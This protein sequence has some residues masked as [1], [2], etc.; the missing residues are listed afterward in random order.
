MAYKIDFEKIEKLTF[1]K[2]ARSLDFFYA[3]SLMFYPPPFIFWRGNTEG[4]ILC[5]L[6]NGEGAIS[7]EFGKTAAQANATNAKNIYK[8]SL[9]V[10]R[11]LKILLKVNFDFFRRVIN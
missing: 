6:K 1:K 11:R 8:L 4:E 7:E 2:Y 9:N 3:S 5:F 10:F